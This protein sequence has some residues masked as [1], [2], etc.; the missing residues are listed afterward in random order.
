MSTK[1]MTANRILILLIA[2]AQVAFGQQVKPPSGC[3]I[4]SNFYSLTLCEDRVQLESMIKQYNYDTHKDSV[5]V[6]VRGRVN[7]DKGPEDWL[8][9]GLRLYHVIADR[10][11]GCMHMDSVITLDCHSVSGLAIFPSIHGRQIGAGDFEGPTVTNS[12]TYNTNGAS[13]NAGAGINIAVI[14]GNF[15]GYPFLTNM[16]PPNASGNFIHYDCTSGPCTLQQLSGAQDDTHGT[17]SAEQAYDHAPAASYRLYDVNSF[18]NASTVVA[19]NAAAQWADVISMSQSKYN[20]GW[21]DNDGIICQAMDSLYPANDF[22]FVHS[23]GNRNQTHYQSSFIDNDNNNRHDYNGVTL[24][25]TLRGNQSGNIFLHWD[26]DPSTADH[27]DLTLSQI[28]SGGNNGCLTNRVTGGLNNSSFEQISISADTAAPDCTVLVNVVS[29]S[30]TTPDFEF[31]SHNVGSAYSQPSTGN[32]TTSPAN[33]TAENI[34]TVAAV[35]HEF[36]DTIPGADVIKWYSSIGPT[37][38]GT[39]SV[40]ITGPTDCYSHVKSP[41]VD[42]FGGTSCATPNV[43]GAAAAV[44]SLYPSWTAKEVRQFLLSN[45]RT[46]RDFGPSGSDDTYGAGGLYLSSYQ[47]NKIYIDQEYGNPN[48]LP[49][50]GVFPWYSL[51][52]T[53]L[54]NTSNTEAILLTDDFLGSVPAVLDKPMMLRTPA[55]SMHRVVD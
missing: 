32:Q 18:N 43:A 8:R 17:Q 14:D 50:N 24:G 26:A 9:H 15:N 52:Q 46:Y 44:W 23:A 3:A 19:M 21:N 38:D 54:G 55:E 37:N 5:K 47:A 39:P 2:F 49:P 22:L 48:L 25:F 30:A 16:T 42:T 10:Y 7:S 35:D 45:A 29:T 13:S 27:Y 36:F 11:I 20:F 41:L 4:S 28:I 53:S 51:S 34:V 6:E 31:W 40:D 1:M 12:V 33:C